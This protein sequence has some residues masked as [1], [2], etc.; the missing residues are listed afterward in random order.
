M[1]K[2]KIV[3]EDSE[4][5]TVTIPLTRKEARDLYDLGFLFSDSNDV[6]DLLKMNCCQDTFW[7]I[8]KK[9]ARVVDT[10]DEGKCYKFDK[11]SRNKLGMVLCKHKFWHSGKPPLWRKIK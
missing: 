6:Q 7:S 1:R 4:K 3:V 10:M 8:H 2:I 9:M 5:G 11:N